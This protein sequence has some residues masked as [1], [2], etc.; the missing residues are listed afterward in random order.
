VRRP[1]PDISEN[2]EDRAT[3]SPIVD[4]MG[5]GGATEYRD[6]DKPPHRSH[7]AGQVA[8]RL[9]T[10]PRATGTEVA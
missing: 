3:I 4:R 10:P 9:T 8:T 6:E 2:S 5:S 7:Q 1:V